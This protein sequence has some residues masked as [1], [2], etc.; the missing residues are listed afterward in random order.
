M[1]IKKLGCLVF[2]LIAFT[3]GVKA[4]TD[5]VLSLKDAV[6]IALKNNYHILLSKNNS[7]VAQNNVTIGNAGFLP[8]VNGDL[9]ATRS[10]QN[11]KQTRSDGSVNNISGAKNSSTSYGPS[12]NWTIFNGF[13]MFANYDELKQ[14]NKLG[15]LQTRDTIQN[16]L[17][18]V[19]STYYNLIN[20]NEGLK[21][22]QGAI[23]ISRIQLR[24]A[25]D[26]F[27]VGRAS[28]L[29]VLNAQV[30]LNTDTANYLNQVQQFKSAKIQMNQL[31][32][33]NL[34][35]DFAVGDTII[36]DDK[37][38]LG[39]ILSKAE[40]Q[41][42]A[43]LSA[44]IN[45]RISEI[46]LKQVKA[47]RY[48]QVALNSGYTIGHSQTPAGFTLS[49]NTR[50]FNYGLTASINIFNGF[51]Q[52]RL[53]RNAKIGIDNANINFKQVTLDVQA[54]ISNLYVSYLSGL[55]LMKL[56][57]SNVEVA[58]RNLDISLEKYKL[59]NITPL[60]IREAQRNYL[61]AQS[62]FFTAQ[63]QSKSAEI[64]LKEI[65]GSINIQ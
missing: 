48:P 54:Q 31:L 11:T 53:E 35:T 25:S 34:Q 51:N 61:D 50:G 27:Q 21:A 32:V 18:S 49:Q 38:V 64:M 12:L 60:E 16:T 26:K 13:G 65:T 39:E 8:Q 23:A 41:N 52:N 59:G 7:T 43:I 14:L 29:D 1:T 22:L 57:Q 20:L 62:K 47:G 5:T 30:N 6:E 24:Y 37:L 33:R 15:E 4:Q 28:K 2:C 40:N 42:P 3:A 19:I 56:G 10:I 63:Y 44:Q 9:T 45:K 46:N 17:A 36:V 58:K 55:D